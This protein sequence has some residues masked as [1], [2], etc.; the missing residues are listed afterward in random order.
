V[1]RVPRLNLS[2][3]A[4]KDDNVVDYTIAFDSPL[5]AAATG[6]GYDSVLTF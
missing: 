2:S 3:L 5:V 6:F 1:C 4:D